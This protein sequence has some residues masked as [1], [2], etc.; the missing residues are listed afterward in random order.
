MNLSNIDAAKSSSHN[1][2]YI[3][4]PQVTLRSKRSANELDVSTASVGLDASISVQQKADDELASFLADVHKDNRLWRLPSTDTS[5]GKWLNIYNQSWEAPAMQA[6]VKAQNLVP[7]SLRLLGSTLTAQKIVDGRLTNLT[8]TPS[9][10]SGWWPI[11]RQVI[12]SAAILDPQKAGL[13]GDGRAFLWPEDVMAFYGADWPLSDVEANK[14]WFSG[15]PA[16]DVAKDPLRSP[17]VRELASREFMDTEQDAALMKTLLSAIK[18]K[19]D[20]EQIDLGKILQDITPGSSFQVA[21]K[22]KPQLLKNLRNHPQMVSILQTPPANWTTQVSLVD[23]KLF[24]KSGDTSG[25][26]HDVTEKVRANSTLAELLDNAIEQAKS[27]GN[28]IKSGARADARQM[29]RFA[30]MDEL[31]ANVSVKELQN[32]LN[33]RL[34]PLPPGNSLGSYARDFLTYPQSPGYLS[35]EQRVRVRRSAPGDDA[36]PTLT[37]LGCS[38]QPWSGKTLEQIRESA[39]QLIAQ[40]LAQGAGLRGCEPILSAL[41]DD[42]LSATGDASPSYRQQMMLTRDLLGIDTELGLKRNHIAGYNLYSAS[43]TGK[44]LSEVRAELERHISVSK[45]IPISQ[46]VLITH[47]LLA[48]V[49]PEFLVKGAGEERVGSL[50]LVNLRTQTALVELASQGS[51]RELSTEQISSRAFLTPFS[52]DH[53]QLQTLETVGPVYDWALAQGIVTAEEDYSP[54]AVKRALTSYNQ[55]LDQHN[56]M[57]RELDNARSTIAARLEVCRQ[58]FERVCPGNDEFFKKRTIYAEPDSLLYRLGKAFL[59]FG[60]S[61]SGGSPSVVDNKPVSTAEQVIDASSIYDLYLS[62]ELTAEN[63]ST[64]QWKFTSTQ[65]REKF[66]SLKAKLST[67]KPIGEVFYDRVNAGLEHLE[68]S[69]L[70]S[71][72]AIM[73]EMPLKDRLRLEYGEV[74]VFGASPIQTS[75][76]G[77]LPQDRAQQKMGPIIFAAD[78]SGTQCYEFVPSTNSYIVRPELLTAMNT[79]TKVDVEFHK[80]RLKILKK[81]HPTLPADIGVKAYFPANKQY[82]GGPAHVPNTYSS[83]RTNN[84]IRVFKDH[85][86]LINRQLMLVDAKGTTHNESIQQRFDAAESFIINTVIPF[87][88]NIEDILSGDAKRVAMGL[89]GLGLEVFGALFVVAGAARAAAKGASIASK[90]AQFG[91]AAIS[92]FN[93]PGA[94]LDTGKSLARLTA[95]GISSVGKAQPGNVGKGIAAFRKLVFG[96]HNYSQSHIRR[97]PKPWTADESLGLLGNTGLINTGIGTVNFAQ[98]TPPIQSSDRAISLRAR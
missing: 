74:V 84:L 14:L 56:V 61:V 20:D 85:E 43:N 1:E 42:P 17:L 40:S 28:I 11:G 8:F 91:K 23:G 5:V 96:G 27:T 93:L 76:A 90:L 19:P 92:M 16:V 3:P 45:K 31:P 71:A 95:I 67:L 7:G 50:A 79:L 58:E 87:K 59:S 57:N 47:A 66:E 25:Q 39:D 78:A 69:E 21:N 12:A 46:A 35:D 55:R 88:S 60:A 49:A 29:L 80:D 81:H 2:T 70:M 52:N 36:Q 64:R 26:W 53:E 97:L 62:G 48:T 33:W 13:V 65:E 75:E 89:L 22:S 54:V 51:S 77:G 44:K 38:P 34:N 24:I 32:L 82:R 73:S 18:D 37:V 15:F 72:R 30:G 83:A 68:K 86:L 94:V 10:G 6:W 9:D 63:A 4:N 41:K 98:D